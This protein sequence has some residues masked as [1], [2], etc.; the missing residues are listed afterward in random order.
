MKLITPATASA[1]YTAAPPTDFT[2]TLSISA[3][4]ILLVSTAEPKPPIAEFPATNLLPLTNVR[5]LCAPNPK[6]SPI[7]CP[8]S[9]E[10]S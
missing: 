2:S 5:V 4:G 3:L 1:P 6:L 10:P 7:F 9:S 8:I